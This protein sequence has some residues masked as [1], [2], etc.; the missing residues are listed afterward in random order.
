MTAPI[1]ARSLLMAS[2]ALS[3]RSIAVLAL[4]WDVMLV[5]LRRALPE[6]TAVT[7]GVV[8]PTAKEPLAKV[9]LTPVAVTDAPAAVFTSN[10]LPMVR[11][12]ASLMLMVVPTVVTVTFS[13]PTVLLMVVDNW[14]A[15]SPASEVLVVAPAMADVKLTLKVVD[16]IDKEKFLAPVSAAADRFN[17][18]S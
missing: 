3:S 14:V 13:N 2:M 16:P 6:N 11:P 7:G 1:C 10:V 15:R 9:V 18:A 17:W 12:C 5:S 8:A 4:A